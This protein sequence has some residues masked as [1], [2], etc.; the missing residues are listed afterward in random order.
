MAITRENRVSFLL[1]DQASPV[2]TY[3]IGHTTPKTH[4]GGLSGTFIAE[5]TRDPH[6]V[7][8]N[9]LDALIETAGIYKRGS[10]F[11]LR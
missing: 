6:W 1:Q 11:I 9:I 7:V 10:M 5:R 3:S 8:V 2:V 4:P